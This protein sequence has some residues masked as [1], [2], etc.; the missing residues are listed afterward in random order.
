MR[1][2]AFAVAI[3]VRR[4]TVLPASIGLWRD[5]WHRAFALDLPSDRVAVIALVTVKYGNLW[6]LL[7]QQFSSSTVGDLATRQHEC[8]GTT[9][10]ISQ[11]VDLGGAP[12]A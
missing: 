7:Q 9:R 11:G 3:E 8:N 5:I 12:T 2:M 6:H 1:S 4:E 10:T